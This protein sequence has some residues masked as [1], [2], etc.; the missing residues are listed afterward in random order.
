MLDPLQIENLLKEQFSGAT[1]QIADPRGD[2]KVYEVYVASSAFL[3]K[4]TKEQ[5]L[6]VLNVLKKPLNGELENIRLETS[7]L[8]ERD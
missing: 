3:E 2:G 8:Y 7:S 1:I 6:M 5:H 4:S